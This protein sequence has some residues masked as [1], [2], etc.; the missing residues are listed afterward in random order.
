MADVFNE[1]GYHALAL[2][3]NNDLGRRIKA[4]NELQDD[5]NPLEI[6]CSVDIL[7]EGVD[8][9]QINMVLFLRP[10][11]SQTVFLQQ[12]GRGLRKYPGKDYVTVLDF[13]GNN[14]ER[15]I[16][17]ALALGTLGTTAYTEKPYLR[18]LINTNFASLEIPGVV[19]DIDE[20]S[21]EEIINFIDRTNFNNKAF[22]KKD[23]EN[24]KSY[25][26]CDTYPKHM[27]YLD[28]EF[29]PNLDRFIKS[30]MGASKNKSYYTFLKKIGEESIPVFTKEENDLVDSIEELLP[31][32]RVNEFAI[33]KQ[34]IDQGSINLE[35]LESLYPKANKE[36]LNYAYDYL[37]KQK[38]L[39][40]DALDPL[41][42]KEEFRDYLE[43]TIDYGLSRYLQE[44]G[45]YEGMYKLYG[46]YT[47]EQI[48]MSL[49][50]EKTMNLKLKGTYYDPTH[51]GETYI[52]VG[53][54]KDEKGKLNYK[55]KFLS[56]KIFQWE[57]Q[58]NTTVDN[59]EGQRLSSTR[60]IHLF[61]RKV[62]NEDGIQLP[63]TYFGTGSFTN[64]RESY[65]EENGQRYPT[66][67]FDVVLDKEVP[68]EY[69]LDFEIPETE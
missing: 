48:G 7:N 61:V 5:D 2:T 69:Y 3:G 36:S 44:F 4:F 52:F 46:N 60:L 18:A 12:L 9:P 63:F 27:D 49:L 39:N 11:E 54:K 34:Y 6:I 8:I 14:Y 20:L 32:V 62:E 37:I 30:H 15:S 59:V 28:Q 56:S 40:N 25:I 47:K 23:Y 29:A 26:Q 68:K 22:L 24:F 38:I 55:D 65:T 35:E 33:L 64:L 19:I 51:P 17:I 31:I 66:L 50:M 45:E 53:L 21:K 57:S 41:K 42:L 1:K 58:N 16:Q 10:T 43:D 13:I 67:L